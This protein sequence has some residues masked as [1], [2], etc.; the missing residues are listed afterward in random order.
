[1]PLDKSCSADAM[2]TN[3]KNLVGKE[4]KAQKQAVAIAY[5]VLRKACGVSSDK[6]RMTPKQIVSFGSK[7]E[8]SG[9]A[10]AAEALAR[11]NVK[12]ADAALPDDVSAELAKLDLRARSAEVKVSLSQGALD[13]LFDKA[14]EKN[15]PPPPAGPE[16]EPDLD[17]DAVIETYSGLVADEVEAAAAKVLERPVFGKILDVRDSGGF[18]EVGTF[19]YTFSFVGAGVKGEGA[20]EVAFGTPLDEAVR[21]RPDPDMPKPLP[22]R[23]KKVF[24]DFAARAKKLKFPSLVEFGLCGGWKHAN[25]CCAFT[26]DG[27]W[28]GEMATK[29]VESFQEWRQPD[30][31]HFVM[32]AAAREVRDAFAGSPFK[33]SDK[34]AV[35][36]VNDDLP[37]PSD[38]ATVYSPS[39]GK[40]VKGERFRGKVEG[41][42]SVFFDPGRYDYDEKSWASEEE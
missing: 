30:F 37:D 21:I 22:P 35:V 10:A 33:P 6:G 27:K 16:D 15:P 38:L 14:V 32:D 4:G 24:K 7:S 11:K 36:E 23:Q 34:V 25:V 19:V 26:L 28:L 2:S 17:E 41:S 1:M 8:A 29:Y 39:L 18:G 12:A 3:T 42:F 20:A 13:R 31:T 9:S 5:S 40:V